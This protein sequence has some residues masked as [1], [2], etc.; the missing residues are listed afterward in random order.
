MM[1]RS[2]DQVDVYNFD[3]DLDF[4]LWGPDQTLLSYNYKGRAVVAKGNISGYRSMCLTDRF[5]YAHYCGKP[6]E[7]FEPSSS[8]GNKVFK[9]D[10]A[11]RL[12]DE[13]VLDKDALYIA[14]DEKRQKLYSLRPY[15]DY[16]IRQY[17]L[18]GSSLWN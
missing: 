17:D 14:V 16:P 9:F 3:G 13:Y 15:D 10:Y 4:M 1:T 18:E 11:G 2:I 7:P 8:F 12:L 6:W 5:I